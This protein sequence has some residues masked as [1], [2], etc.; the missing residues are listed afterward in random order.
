[1]IEDVGV[2]HSLFGVAVSIHFVYNGF[3]LIDPGQQTEFLRVQ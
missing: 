2:T 3:E 1:M